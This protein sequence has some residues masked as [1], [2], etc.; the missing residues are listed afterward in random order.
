MTHSLYAKFILG[1]LVFGL[2]GFVFIATFSSHITYRY[3]IS[4]E[5]EALYDEANLLAGTY[6][7]T[8]PGLGFGSAGCRR[9]GDRS[10]LSCG[11]RNQKL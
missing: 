2:I 7:D 3:L 6:S 11:N 5:S 10:V 8:R 4:E 9:G 1:Y